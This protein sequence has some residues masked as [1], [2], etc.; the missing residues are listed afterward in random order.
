MSNLNKDTLG[1]PRDVSRHRTL[2]FF[3]RG[4]S[5]HLHR[6]KCCVQDAGVPN[7]TFTFI[8]NQCCWLGGDTMLYSILRVKPKPNEPRHTEKP[9][10]RRGHRIL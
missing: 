9:R 2:A 4:V 1:D 7:C 6:V 5:R 3:T 10:S 8:S